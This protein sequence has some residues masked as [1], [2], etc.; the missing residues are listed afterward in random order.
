MFGLT[1]HVTEPP[2]SRGHTLNVLISKGIVISNVDV[3]HVALADH[4]CLFFDLSVT[5]KPAVESAVV[6]GRLLHDSTGTQFMEM[7]RF[8]NT[9]CS[10]VDDLLNIL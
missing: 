3:V 10:N 9:P 4:F 2:H 6:W 7:I 5:P 8:E 1:Q